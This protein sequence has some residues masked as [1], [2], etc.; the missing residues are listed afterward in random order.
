MRSRRAAIV[1]PYGC[2][3]HTINRPASSA[4]ARA[5]TCT[6]PCR[7]RSGHHRMP[8]F[9][10]LSTVAD[11]VLSESVKA[12][13]RRCRT[14]GRDAERS[15]PARNL[16]VR[17]STCRSLKRPLV[18]VVR[19]HISEGR[20]RLSGLVLPQILSNSV[21]GASFGSCLFV[22]ASIHPGTR[23]KPLT[24]WVPSG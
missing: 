2:R 3:P 20:S 18:D 8:C 7:G 21:N 13:P 9:S 10:V 19:H 4:P 1:L 17:A 24:V 11:D 23:R 5:D 16:G 6:M 14:Y 22:A 12:R 15:G